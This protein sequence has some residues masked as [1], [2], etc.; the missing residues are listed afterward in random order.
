MKFH[1]IAPGRYQTPDGR[2]TIQR[3]EVE[4]TDFGPA[5]TAWFWQDGI[6]DAHDWHPT[7][8]AAVVA[9]I[10]WIDGEATK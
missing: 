5:Q 3:V 10:D 9:L 8:A 4:A 7:K 1:R 2:Y 6:E